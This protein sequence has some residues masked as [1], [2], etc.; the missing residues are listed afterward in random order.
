MLG[1]FDPLQEVE[2][3]GSL[4]LAWALGRLEVREGEAHCQW[5]VMRRGTT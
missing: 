3:I 4:D 2:N 1:A 5:A